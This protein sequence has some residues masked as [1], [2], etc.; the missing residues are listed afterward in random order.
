[1]EARAHNVYTGKQAIVLKTN[2]KFVSIDEDGNPI[3]I[4]EKGRIRVGNLIELEP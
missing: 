3:P 4:G 2:I 1:M